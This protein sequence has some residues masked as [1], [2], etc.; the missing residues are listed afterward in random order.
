MA[1]F[2]S[3]ENI[4]KKFGRQTVLS[5][6][7]FSV[8]KGKIFS[9]LGPSGCGKTTLLRICAG[10]ESPDSGRV[11]LDGRD[12]TDLVPNDRPVN[13][14]F[15]NYALFPHMTIWENI[16]FGPRVDK[17]PKQE[18]ASEVEKYLEMIQMTSHAYKKPAQLSG[19]MRQRVAL[20]RALINHPQ[21]L[22]LDEPLAALDLK[23]RQRMLV[24]L[25]ELHDKIGITFVYVTHDQ[26][27]A[28]SIS[29]DVA[30]MNQGIIEQM[31]PPAEIYEAPKSSFVA[32]FI[33]DTNFFDGTVTEITDN[34]Y[35][36]VQ[37]EN[38]GNQ[39]MLIFNDRRLNAGDG[40]HVSIRPE[41]IDISGEHP[42][43]DRK[44]N[45]IKGHVE[46]IIYMGNST[47]FWIRVGR[48]LISV[49]KQHSAFLLDQKPIRWKQEVWL[50]W[51]ADNGY[52]L[53]NFHDADRSLL[54]INV[55]EPQK[56][57]KGHKRK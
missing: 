30:V 3:F 17:R 50:A 56:P 7:S 35:S 54:P 23:L 38:M 39:Q 10:L 29:D 1:G 2:L 44:K 6:V 37:L 48:Q 11:I 18:I 47:K 9:L 42:E 14:V 57:E 43:P 20:A 19:G 15:Q 27:E 16:A 46:D 22:L 32:A 13:T 33:G 49:Q 5:D 26:S 4:S 31:G 12:I 41:K 51:H 45:I 21:V 36:R 8:E 25:D 53:D 40:V 52:I 55:S 34:D 28:M 24:E